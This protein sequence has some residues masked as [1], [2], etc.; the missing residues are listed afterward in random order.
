MV[1][2]HA[3]IEHICEDRVDKLLKGSWGIGEA[4]G[5]HLPLIGAIASSEG[6]FPLI[7][8][9]NVNQVVSMPK[10]NFSIDLCVTW[11]VKKVGDEG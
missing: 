7:A 5:H 3:D 2:Y 6:G 9:G 10:I 11:G 1:Y 4:E 8:L